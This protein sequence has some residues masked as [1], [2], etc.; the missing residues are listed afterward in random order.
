[1]RHRLK[2]AEPTTEPDALWL[3]DYLDLE[4]ETCVCIW[5]GTELPCAQCEL[6]GSEVRHHG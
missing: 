5:H 2:T 6:L 4:P 1:M 3:S